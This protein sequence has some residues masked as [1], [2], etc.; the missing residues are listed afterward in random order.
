MFDENCEPKIV[1]FEHFKYEGTIIFRDNNSER[2]HEYYIAPEIILNSDLDYTFYVD[3]YTF[4]YFL[5]RMFQFALFKSYLVSQ[6]DKF[7]NGVAKGV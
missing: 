1:G 4:A 2:I 3:V 6:K 5:Y 7:M